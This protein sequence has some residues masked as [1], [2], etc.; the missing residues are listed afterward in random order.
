VNKQLFKIPIS[1]KGKDIIF[2]ANLAGG[3]K[4][5]VIWLIT[6][7]WPLIKNNHDIGKLVVIGKNAPD[8]LKIILKKD[9]SIQYIE[10][11]SNLKDAFIG[12]SVMIA[13]SFKNYGLIN[14]VIE[15][16]A[17]GVPV[18]GDYGSFNG[19]P[20]FRNNIHGIIAK[21]SKSMAEEIIALIGS[22]QKRENMAIAARNL[23]RL[24]FEWDKRIDE[25]DKKIRSIIG[26]KDFSHSKKTEIYL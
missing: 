7:V 2:L 19:I 25:L 26:K 3:Y 9:E 22:P 1:S 11:V 20:N 14:K 18:V 21:D 13:P 10:Y 4:H 6:N 15:S 23:V 17:A 24:H 12:K 16:M 8:Y 5:I